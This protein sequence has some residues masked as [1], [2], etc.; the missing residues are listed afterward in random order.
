MSEGRVPS[1][2]AIPRLQLP[3]GWRGTPE[4]VP[5]AREAT[6]GTE[7][8]RGRPRIGGRVPGDTRTRTPAQQLTPATIQLYRARAG[9]GR[10]RWIT[11]R[12]PTAHAHRTWR[13]G[14]D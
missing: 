14:Q 2:S 12:S 6:T 4:A 1:S 8:L 7:E 9:G 5:D 10:G 3:N 11:R 13:I